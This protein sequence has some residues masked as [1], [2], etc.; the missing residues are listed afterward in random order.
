ME[1]IAQLQVII[2]HPIAMIGVQYLYTFH[3]HAKTKK[4]WQVFSMWLLQLIGI[5]L[6]RY[7][8]HN[9][10]F[11][12]ELFRIISSQWHKTCQQL[13]IH[14]VSLKISWIWCPKTCFICWCFLWFCSSSK[15]YIASFKVTRFSFC[16]FAYALNSN[17]WI[18]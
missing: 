18:C 7:C 6:M 5:M 14:L 11:L 2:E 15:Y 17:M 13:S 3:I 12:I 8:I 4:S 1:I 10:Y 16:I 9:Q